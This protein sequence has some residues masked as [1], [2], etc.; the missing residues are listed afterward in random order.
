MT[1]R[2]RYVPGFEILEHG[3]IWHEDSRGLDSFV[4]GRIH[5]VFFARVNSDLFGETEFRTGTELRRFSR[6]LTLNERDHEEHLNE[7][8]RIRRCA[9]RAGARPCLLIP[10]EANEYIL[11]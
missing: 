10:G 5:G 9:A 11:V 2:I 6:F 8:E 3:K 1:V 4:I 7:S